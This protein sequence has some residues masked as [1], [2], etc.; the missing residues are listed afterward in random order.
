MAVSTGLYS[1]VVPRPQQMGQVIGGMVQ[2]MHGEQQ[3]REN[4]RRDT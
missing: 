3:S 2:S 4:N 1:R